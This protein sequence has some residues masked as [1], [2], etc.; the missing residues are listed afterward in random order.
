MLKIKLSK[1]GAKKNPKYRIIVS[2]ARSKRNGKYIEALGS[3]DP[4]P[5]QQKVEL[6]MDRYAHWVTKGAKPTLA[7]G[8]LVKRF[9]RSQS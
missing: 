8:H 1:I 9:A 7:V 3:Y 4:M 6:K 5:E 2:E